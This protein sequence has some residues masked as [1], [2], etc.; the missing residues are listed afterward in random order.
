MLI[1]TNTEIPF[2]QITDERW[3]LRRREFLQLGA[4]LVG[5]IAGGALVACANDAVDAAMG[6]TTSAA[7]QTPLPGV[8]K[9]MVTTTEPVN[10]F[11]EITGYNNYYEFGLRKSDPAKY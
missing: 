11:E 9:K 1:K 4:G 2:S 5:A 6:T 7:P 10:K 8:T 3:Y